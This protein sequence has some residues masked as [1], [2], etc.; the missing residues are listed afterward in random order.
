MPGWWLALRVE[1][2]HILNIVVYINLVSYISADL[3]S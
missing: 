3:I 1:I 2:P